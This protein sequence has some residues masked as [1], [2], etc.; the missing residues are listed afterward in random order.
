M[1]YG[2][3]N[4]VTSSKA[5]AAYVAGATGKGIKVG[6]VDSGINPLLAEFAGRIDLVNS[7]DVTGGNRGLGDSNGHGTAVTA[8]IAGAKN[9]IGT[10][11]VAFDATIV[12]L[13][14]D[15]PG[16]CATSDGCNFFDSAI[17]AGIDAATTA[18]V[19]VINLSLGG[20]APNQTLLSA[21][22]RAVNAGIVLVI[23]AGN[24]GRTSAGD[25]S[26]PFALVPAQQ[27][28]GQVIIAGSIGAPNGSGGTNLNA[29]SDFSNKAGA[30]A[31]NYLAALGYSNLTIDNT[32]AQFYY[33]GTSFSAPTIVGAVALMA[34]A[35]PTLTAAQ[36]VTILF[37]SADDLG[38]AGVDS[39][40]GHG[41]LN[42]ER[43][44]APQ[45]ATSLASSKV[46]VG[47]DTSGDLPAAAGDATDP[48]NGG[49]GAIVLDGYSRAFTI[50]L[51][52][53]LRRAAIDAPL[54]RALSQGVRSNSVSAGPISVSLTVADQR[55][56]P[57]GFSL[58]ENGIGPQD[59]AKSKLLAAS[60]V[61]RISDRTAIAFGFSEG[62]KAMERKLSGADAGAFLIARDIA[63]DPGFAAKRDGGVALRQNLGPIG[64]TLSAET[65]E[66]WHE[67]RTT[68][69]GS[70]YRWTSLMV[71]RKFGRNWVSAGISRLD[72][73]HSLLGGR[74]GKAFGGAGNA[75]SLFLDLEARREFGA[76]I[77]ASASARH[78]WTNFSGGSFQSGAYAFDLS[79]WGVFG[80][81]DRIG[82]RIAQPLRIEQGGFA[83]M[84]PTAYDYG[85]GSATETLS[86]FSLSPS[87]REID[88]EVS[89]SRPFAGGWLGGNLYLRRQPGHIAKANADVGAAVR[90]TLG[91]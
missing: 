73:E 7:R 82:L 75:S 25:N 4:F 1:E 57:G 56:R 11:G 27:F 68:A 51:A 15:D 8:V 48:V 58:V 89:Y 12:S 41:R 63:G 59:L 83:L 2:S 60:A 36:I 50:N 45:G 30:G 17:A 88:S 81:D 37:N 5:L 91:F 32:G 46:A 10:H 78:G 29:L 66:V 18:G 87:G 86:R 52:A 72:E 54:H 62:A 74:V 16:S 13:R 19:R 26:D 53:Q 64:L 3:S 61:A 55:L 90:Y 43:A 39:I 31:S 22:Q 49:L 85:S 70:P 80:S 9:D 65:G 76:H 44:F 67:D 38:V 14:A 28:P 34:Q 40:Y 23:A 33:S 79:K 47:V 69:T 24:D 6:I 20:S 21:M 71:D 77:V 35:F 42:I 84:L